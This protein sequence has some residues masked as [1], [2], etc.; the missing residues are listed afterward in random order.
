MKL[1]TPTALPLSLALIAL[2][3]AEISKANL[4]AGEGLILNF[5]DPN[6]SAETGG[7]HPVEIAINAEGKLLY[8]TDFAYYGQ[9]LY[10]ELGK[11]LDFDFSYGLFQQM[12]RDYPLH[13]GAQLFALWQQNFCSYVTWGVFEVKYSVL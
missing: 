11:S 13:E 8:I 2:L 9:G 6:Y 1:T 10:A 3:E 4:P 5:K 7:F 12:G